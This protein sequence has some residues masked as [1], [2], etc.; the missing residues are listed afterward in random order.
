MREIIQRMLWFTIVASA[1]AYAVYLAA[2][3]IVNAQASG[4]YEAV[5]IRDELAAGQHQLSGMIMVPT[6]CDQLS[7]HTQTLSSSQ[8]MLVFTTWHESS[9][10]CAA[11]TTPRYFRAT[12]F[13]PAAGVDFA[14]TLDGAGLPIV[15]MPTVVH[16]AK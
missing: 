13:A 15:V 12:L 3:S 8:F 16:P 10:M 7:V 2:G 1:I 4:A 11:D 9:V 6:P 5:I 14:A